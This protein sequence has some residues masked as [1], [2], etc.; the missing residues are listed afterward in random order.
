MTLKKG[1]GSDE[2]VHDKARY[3]VIAIENDAPDYIKTDIN[4][5][6]RFYNDDDDIGNATRGYPLEDQ[7]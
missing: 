3:K 7:T 5:L 6:G 4:T 1:H 2:Y